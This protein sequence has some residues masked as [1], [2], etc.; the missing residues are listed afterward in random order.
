MHVWKNTN[1][2][3]AQKLRTGFMMASRMHMHMHGRAELV[4]VVERFCFQ[5]SSRRSGY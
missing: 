2:F 3:T 5:H 4:Q 1:A